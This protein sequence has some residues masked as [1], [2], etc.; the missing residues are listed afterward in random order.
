MRS[1]G[2]FVMGIVV[3]MIAAI[4]FSGIANS[5]SHP[6]VDVT[7]PDRPD[8]VQMYKYVVDD[9]V[10]VCSD[11]YVSHDFI[12]LYYCNNYGNWTLRINDWSHFDFQP[13]VK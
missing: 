5:A 12:R 2:V 13:V 11:H 7:P 6:T 4:I 3:G 10:Y 9:Q 1:D 8:E